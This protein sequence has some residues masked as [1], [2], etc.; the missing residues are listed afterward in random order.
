MFLSK[1]NLMNEG[2]EKGGTLFTKG[3]GSKIYINKQKYLD[4]SF[5][6]GTNLL[7]H[8]STIYKKAISKL[9]VDKI[10]NLA[11]KN[12]QAIELSKTIKKLY[13][14]Y[15]KF[16]FCNSGTEAVFKS[17]RIARA[18]TKKKLII[19][20]SGSWHGSVNELLFTTNSKSKIVELS[21]GLEVSAKKN[22]KFIPY[23]DIQ[24]SKKILNRYQKKI[25][26]V[27]IEP[28]QGC[29]PILAKEYL[30]F[31]DHYCRKKKILLIFD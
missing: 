26:C 31:L 14:Q 6:A 17:L 30:N 19:S 28:I 4:L 3:I 15:S 12:T 11:A 27:I 13:P 7:G 25:M 21:K 1:K 23:N 2:Y 8:N 9:V 10:S 24:E 18:V 16:I 29:L 22:L 5:C 20:V